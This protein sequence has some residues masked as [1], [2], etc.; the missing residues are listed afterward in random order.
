MSQMREE[1]GKS[2]LKSAVIQLFCQNFII[3]MH[4]Q[5]LKYNIYI[6]ISGMNED[7]QDVVDLFDGGMMATRV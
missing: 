3:K 2:N 4:L 5:I 6:M 1:T 7:R